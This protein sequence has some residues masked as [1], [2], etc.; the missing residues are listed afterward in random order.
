[1]LHVGELGDNF[2]NGSS[3]SIFTW[4]LGTELGSGLQS[5]EG[6]HQLN[7]HTSPH[8]LFQSRTSQT[9]DVRRS[10]RRSR[11]GCGHGLGFVVCLFC[12]YEGN[13]SHLTL[14]Q[15]QRNA[16]FV[17]AQ[18]FFPESLSSAD[19]ASFP[20]WKVRGLTTAP[21]SRPHL[22]SAPPDLKS[23]RCSDVKAARPS[24]GLSRA[25]NRL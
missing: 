25:A 23:L 1:M 15:K 9:L 5:M 11:L 12:I 18:F 21:G 8:P 4:A 16:I 22:Q 14:E 13:L 24:A 6:P 10:W 17:F 2:Q 19:P 20:S 3:S 7:H